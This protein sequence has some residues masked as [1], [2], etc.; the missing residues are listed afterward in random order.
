MIMSRRRH[1]RGAAALEFALVTPLLLT[2]FAG[3]LSFG[4]MVYAQF[5]LG[6]LTAQTART[7]VAMQPSLSGDPRSSLTA[8]ATTTFNQLY[9][10]SSPHLCD[11]A[12]NIKPTTQLIG[13]SV[14]ADHPTYLLTVQVNCKKNYLNILNSYIKGNLTSQD[15]LATSAMPFTP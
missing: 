6:Q 13:T 5:Q 11:G 15:L 3:I 2:L 10:N 9:Q 4:L 12:L 8:C 7:C 1:S 14:G